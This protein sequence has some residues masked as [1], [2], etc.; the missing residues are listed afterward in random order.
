MKDV[1][2]EIGDIIFNYRVGLMATCGEEILV[3]VNPDID[4]VT[5]PGGRVKTM[6]ASK[7]GLK[8]E[9]YEELH[10]NIKDKECNIRGIVE[11]FFELDGKKY[12]ELFFLYQMEVDKNH[13]LYKGDLINK[14]SIKSYFKWVKKTDLAKENLLPKVVRSWVAKEGFDITVLR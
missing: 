2:V 10:Y 6:E 7:E 11:N 12:H 1:T 14:D 8:R 5:L 4:F 9:I 3:E 13:R